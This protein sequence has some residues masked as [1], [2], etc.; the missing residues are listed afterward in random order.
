MAMW[1]AMMKEQQI[2]PPSDLQASLDDSDNNFAGGVYGSY[3]VGAHRYGGMRQ[4]Y[5]FPEENVGFLRMPTFKGE[6]YGPANVET[7]GLCLWS[8]SKVA[9]QNWA[10][11]EFLVSPWA[12]GK[13]ALGGELIPTRKSVAQT[14]EFKNLPARLSHLNLLSQAVA[15]WG[16][17]NP[18]APVPYAPH[19]LL[20]YHR[21]VSENLPLEKALQDAAAEYNK[22][23]A[24]SKK[25]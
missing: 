12:D 25:K 14:P 20:A 6:K 2:Q 22:Q 4:N 17:S 7:R 3:L 15:D 10:Y 18:Q 24:E 23:V 9:D 16:Y 1:T 21:I 5:T 8:G 13:M 19:L 11:A